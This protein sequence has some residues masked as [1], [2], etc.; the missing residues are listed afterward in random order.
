M[1]IE[2]EFK[3]KIA[4]HISRLT[5]DIMPVL[6][7]LI[8]Y[9]YPKEVDT[10][11]FEIFV[12]GFSS[13]F[14]VRAFFMDENN[15]EYFIMVDGKAEYPS[16]VDPDLLKIDYVYPYELEEEYTNKDDSLEPWHIATN[17]LIDWFSKCWLTAGGKNF[18]LNAN[19]ALHDSNHEFDLRESKWVERW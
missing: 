7:E 15:S 18:K 13:E 16:P 8:E 14:P 9:D 3:V 10:L 2:E 19:I 17:E 4:E 11:A 12:D 6:K 5:D 1:S